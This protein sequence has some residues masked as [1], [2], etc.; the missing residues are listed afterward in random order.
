MY[1]VSFVVFTLFLSDSMVP[2]FHFLN[3]AFMDPIRAS[4]TCYC[5]TTFSV[6]YYN[7]SIFH[8]FPYTLG[9]D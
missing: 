6:F 2:F 5:L 7:S 9:D 8:M 1:S 4:L 3:T